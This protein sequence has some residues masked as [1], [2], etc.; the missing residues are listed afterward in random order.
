VPEEAL[1]IPDVP[2]EISVRAAQVRLS[3]MAQDLGR[4]LSEAHR[5]TDELKT[6]LTSSEE[7]DQEDIRLFTNF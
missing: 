2:D 6:E 5:Q 3:L 7:E 1:C 4:F